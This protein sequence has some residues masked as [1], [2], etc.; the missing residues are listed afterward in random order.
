[1][2]DAAVGS[3]WRMLSRDELALVAGGSNTIDVTATWSWDAYHDY[4][5]GNYSEGDYDNYNDSGGSAEAPPTPSEP[6]CSEANLV[7]GINVPDGAKYWLPEG[8]DG[9]YLIAA[10]NYLSAYRANHSGPAVIAE[11]GRMYTDRNHPHYIDF[12]DW[13]TPNGPPGSVGASQP[14][15]YYSTAAGATVSGSPYEAFGNFF[16]GMAGTWAGIAPDILYAAA[17]LYQE[18]NT[19]WIPS[20]SPEDQPHVNKGIGAAR[21]YVANPHV[22]FYVEVGDCSTGSASQSIGSG[23]LAAP[24][25][26]AQAATNPTY[27]NGLWEGLRAAYQT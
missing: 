5:F 22:L 3:S 11:F 21:A 7:A 24:E 8:V 20:D 16:Y 23:S 19:S 27:Y 10:L 9:P 18:G 13:G 1:M 25:A 2:S 14:Y 6:S 4:F 12:K 15:S 26:Y 17:A